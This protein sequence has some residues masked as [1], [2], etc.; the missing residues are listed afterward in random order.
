MGGEDGS[1]NMMPLDDNLNS[2][3]LSAFERD[4][5][6]K[7]IELHGEADVFITFYFDDSVSPTRPTSLSYTIKAPAVPKLKLSAFSQTRE[8]DNP[9]PSGWNEGCLCP[10]VLDK[11]KKKPCKK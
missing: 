2:G 11:A 6:K 5:V 8:F 4:V 10:G 9:L 7:K 3:K 1:A